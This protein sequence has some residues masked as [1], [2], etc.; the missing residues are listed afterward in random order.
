[1]LTLRFF[2]KSS[3][4]GRHNAG[5]HFAKGVQGQAH[6]TFRFRGQSLGLSQV[7]RASLT[8]SCVLYGEK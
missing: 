8:K 4:P 5:G 3:A 2:H 7:R 6:V 1:M